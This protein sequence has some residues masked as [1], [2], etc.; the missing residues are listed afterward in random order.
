MQPWTDACRC[1]SGG[2]DVAGY[3]C[4]DVSA[5]HCTAH[6]HVPHTRGSSLLSLQRGHHAM[7]RGGHPGRRP[8]KSPASI[9]RSCARANNS[10]RLC[11]T[12]PLPKSARQPL[13]LAVRGV[14]SP[15]LLWCLGLG[16]VRD[17]PV[18]C[19]CCV[20]PALLS[21]STRASI[22][23]LRVG[24]GTSKASKQR[25]AQRPNRRE[26]A[27]HCRRGGVVAEE[28]PTSSFCQ[29][30]DRAVFSTAASRQCTSEDA[31]V[32]AWA[33]GPDTICRHATLAPPIPPLLRAPA[34]GHA[35]HEP[36]D[37]SPIGTMDKY[38]P[39]LEGLSFDHLD[40]LGRIGLEP[41]LD[42]GTAIPS[43]PR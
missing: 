10:A 38:M 28:D 21:S 2:D 31:S 26:R 19:R 30:V 36:E 20:A 25:Q 43:C 34:F 24:M 40:T 39:T 23:R 32:L 6:A 29:W 1:G 41:S 37:S 8:H 27:A 12:A 5:A 7:G 15:L 22:S 18:R 13:P 4:Q 11:S 42:M 35:D 16:A 14:V 9:A 3:L 17:C 33:A